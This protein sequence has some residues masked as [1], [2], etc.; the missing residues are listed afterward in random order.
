VDRL[1]DEFEESTWQAF[2]LT[3]IENRTAPEAAACLEMTPN[4]VRI[5][6]WRVLSRLRDAADAYQT[7][8]RNPVLPE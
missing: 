5:A 1:E 6:K 8:R 4:A 2:W 7:D 3:V